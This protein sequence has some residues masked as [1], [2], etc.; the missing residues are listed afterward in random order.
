[1]LNAASYL[2]GLEARSGDL[3]GF[4]ESIANGAVMSNQGGRMGDARKDEAEWAKCLPK[5]I[6]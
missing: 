6:F 1:M 4:P 2:L 3:K 5:L